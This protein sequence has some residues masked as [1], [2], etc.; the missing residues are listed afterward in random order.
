VQ[1]WSAGQYALDGVMSVQRARVQGSLLAALTTE[2]RARLDALRGKG[3]TSWPVLDEPT[4]LRGLTHDEKVAVMTYAGDMFSWYMGSVDADIYFCPERHGTYFG[5]FYLKDAPAVGNPGY[6]IDTTITGNLGAALIAALNPA[7]AK[8][9]TNL[10]SAQR[11]SLTDIVKV[12]REISLELRKALAGGSISDATVA[13]LMKRY[14]AD[15]GQISYL[16]ATAFAA[17]GSTLTSTERSKLTALRTKLIG[18]LTPTGAYL[19]ASPIAVPK[20][21][22]TDFLF[23]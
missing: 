14:G 4:D 17:V 1:Q 8:T 12:R 10:V 16:Y 15:D 22:T 5:S 13:S 7:H 3:M 6:S 23:K 9:I 11:A 18:S 20:A 21:V 2:Q 19:Y